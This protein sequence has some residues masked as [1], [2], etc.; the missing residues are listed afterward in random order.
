MLI[1]LTL[2]KYLLSPNYVSGT[3]LG[4][5]DKTVSKTSPFTYGVHVFWGEGKLE[6]EH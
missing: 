4:V 3:A 5:R 6:K 2:S 1:Q